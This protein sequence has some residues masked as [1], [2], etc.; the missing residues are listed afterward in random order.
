[1][2]YIIGFII[3]ALVVMVL[4]GGRVKDT[5]E[6][7]SKI[8]LKEEKKAYDQEQQKLYEKKEYNKYLRTI[9]WN[10]LVF[11]IYER[12]SFRC[13]QCFKDLSKRNGNVHH[14]HYNNIYKEKLE[15]LVLV[16]PDCH[17]LIHYY[18]EHILPLAKNKNILSETQFLQARE[19]FN[20]K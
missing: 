4:I 20:Q 9:D 14:I 8:D 5:E 15:D 3:L 11:A 13:Q 2:I 18:Y 7:E 1:M 19:V 12:D 16:C 17:Q 10:K 6:P